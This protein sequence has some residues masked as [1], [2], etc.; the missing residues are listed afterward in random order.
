MFQRQSLKNTLS[1]TVSLKTDTE[2]SEPG[3]SDS[4]NSYSGSIIFFR[5]DDEEMVFVCMIQLPDDA[6]ADLFFGFGQ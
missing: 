5:P 3:G 6:F 4:E 2:K 1:E